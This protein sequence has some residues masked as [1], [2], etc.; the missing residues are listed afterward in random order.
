M[1][2]DDELALEETAGSTAPADLGSTDLETGLT[3]GGTGTEI[4]AREPIGGTEARDQEDLAS[5]E[6]D[7]GPETGNTAY[8][9]E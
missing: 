9:T 4:S 2:R 5:G 8:R 7:I 6:P 3:A 1:E